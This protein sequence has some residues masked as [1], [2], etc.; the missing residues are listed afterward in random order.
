MLAWLER[1]TLESV[2][3]YIDQHLDS[4]ISRYTD[5]QYPLYYKVK[6]C[7]PWASAMD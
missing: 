2:Q 7:W 5:M 1:I 6:C 4:I 3:N